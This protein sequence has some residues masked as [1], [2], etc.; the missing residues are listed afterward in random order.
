LKGRRLRAELSTHAIE[1]LSRND[2]VL[3]AKIDQVAP[4]PA[5]A[6]TAD[7]PARPRSR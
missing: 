2:F 6:A 3:A 5:P 1:G 7:R 4:A